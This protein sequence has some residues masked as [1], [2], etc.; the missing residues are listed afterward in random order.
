MKRACLTLVVLYALFALGL[1]AWFAA[2][3]RI[4]IPGVL[5]DPASIASRPRLG[6]IGALLRATARS[7]GCGSARSFATRRQASV[8]P[9]A[10]AE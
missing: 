2:G 10:A 9:T 4:P 5:P 3:W 8:R 6:L 7:P 1:Y